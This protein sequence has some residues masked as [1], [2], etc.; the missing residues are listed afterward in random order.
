MSITSLNLN[1]L[2]TFLSSN[3]PEKICL[4]FL[5]AEH[6]EADKQKSNGCHTHYQ[7]IRDC[8]EELHELGE[9]V[10]AEL[11]LATEVVVVSRYELAEGHSAVR[12][13][14][15]QVHHLLPKLLSA[16]HFLHS[17]LW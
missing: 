9:P 10:V 2:L 8:L 13:V 11:A 3:R 4:N 15:K 12:L 5:T 14:T 7:D 17:A 6:W 1:I 16:F